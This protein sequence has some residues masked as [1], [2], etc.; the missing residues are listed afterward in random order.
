MTPEDLPHIFDRFYRAGPSRGIEPEGS[1]LGLAIVRM[2]AELH[3]GRVTAISDPGKGSTFIF[4]IP[5]AGGRQRD[6]ETAYSFAGPP[7]H[8]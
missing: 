2:I 1:G 5:V 4:H 7:S 8:G 6:D 3:R